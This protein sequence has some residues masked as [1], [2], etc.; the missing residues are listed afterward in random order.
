MTKKDQALEMTVTDTAV[1][2]IDPQIDV[3]SEK[4]ANWGGLIWTCYD[5]C[6]LSC[7][8]PSFMGKC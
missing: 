6:F 8:H 5:E 4:G 7:Q 2:F 1:V 3:L